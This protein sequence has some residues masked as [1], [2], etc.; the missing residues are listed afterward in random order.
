VSPVPILQILDRK[1]LDGTWTK[2]DGTEEK[3]KQ[4]LLNYCYGHRNSSLLFFPYVSVHNACVQ[5]R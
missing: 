5:V 2:E 1:A 4:L 3:K